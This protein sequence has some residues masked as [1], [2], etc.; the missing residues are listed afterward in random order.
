MNY[1][2]M[3]GVLLAGYGLYKGVEAYQ[4]QTDIAEKAEDARKKIKIEKEK[5]DV[6][7][8][9]AEGILA[10]QGWFNQKILRFQEEEEDAPPIDVAPPMGNFE[11]LEF[12][13]GGK[14]SVDDGVKVDSYEKGGVV[15]E[16]GCDNTE[17]DGD[18]Q[19]GI[20]MEYGGKVEN[21]DEIEDYE[22]IEKYK[23]GGKVPDNV[24]NPSLYKKAKAKYSD[25]K[26]SAYK[27]SLIVKEYK[28]LGGKY[29]GK[30]TKKG[31]TQWHREEWSTADGSKTY[32]KKGD[33]FRPTKKVADDT[34]KTMGELSK[35]DI[36]KAE[37]EKK[38]T[39]R[40]KKYK[41]G[42]SVKH[43]FKKSESK[44]EIAS[45]I[46]CNKPQPSTR[47]GKRKMVKACEDGKEKLIHWGDSNLGAHPND[48]KRKK[49]FRARHKC[50]TNPPD[51]MTAR[52]YACKDW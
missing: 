19:I 1:G 11:D 33:I 8:E 6:R 34:P 42:G 51:K 24:V 46:A 32:Q 2:V 9:N 38:K 41:K 7:V 52:Y 14:I 49:S 17:E 36:E 25:M 18:G 15:Q 10:D 30:K 50:D 21:K 28:K 27:S 35:K 43:P 12:R 47:K 40:V 29:R 20:I 48:P 4:K 39:G 23:E 44:K 3:G 22:E 16:C 26:H 45:D 37:S 13:K 31:L 5:A